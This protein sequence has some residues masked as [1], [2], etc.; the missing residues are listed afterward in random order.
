MQLKI[1]NLKYRKIEEPVDIS[2]IIMR[3]R[4][5]D[6]TLRRVSQK[7]ISAFHEKREVVS[8]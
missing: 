6:I 2:N 8:P 1:C 7:F 4:R 5:I 3:G